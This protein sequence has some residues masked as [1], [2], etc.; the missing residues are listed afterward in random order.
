MR[1]PEGSERALNLSTTY[2]NY[3]GGYFPEHG[4]F[5]SPHTGVY[6]VA[7]STEFILGAHSLGELVFSNGHRMTLIRNK[8]KAS[9]SFL[10][11]FALVELQ[12]GEHMWFE[13]VHGAAVK[14]N[15]AG[16]SMAAFLIFKT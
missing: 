14:Q 12:K 10:T 5:K 15:P 6:M 1:H 11:A 4:Y 16:M 3:G 13:L 8:A 7:V 2:L 9:G